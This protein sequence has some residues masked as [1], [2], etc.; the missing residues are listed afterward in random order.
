MEER[1][2]KRGDKREGAGRH[3]GEDTKIISVRLETDLLIKIPPKTN[4]SK[5]INDAVREAMKRDG[6]I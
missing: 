3:K 5:Y 4:R 1:K 6:F 2:K